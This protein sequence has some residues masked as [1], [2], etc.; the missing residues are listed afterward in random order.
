MIWL[1]FSA[2]GGLLF[3]AV[4]A[5]SLTVFGIKK[6]I[7]QKS[8]TDYSETVGEEHKREVE[9]LIA[10]YT[11]RYNKNAKGMIVRKTFGLTRRK[12]KKPDDGKGE[13]GEKAKSVDYTELVNEVAKI[14]RP[15]AYKPFLDLSERQIFAFSRE[16]ISK[17]RAMLDA[18][19][20][21]IVKTI[22]VSTVLGATNLSQAIMKNG[23]MKEV[24]KA[25]GKCKKVV[26]YVGLA[27]P[28]R[29]IKNYLNAVFVCGAIKSVMRCT[30]RVVATEAANLF[31]APEK[32]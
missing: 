17:V 8:V 3:G 7:T 24:A 31:S 20:L 27:N 19:G 30:I 29:Y 28:V 26:G 4:V 25:F 1:I 18:S 13:K 12:K 5:V 22:P 9:A 32:C 15:S 6:K 10:E 21:E 2:I 11:A 14:F 16:I 23:A